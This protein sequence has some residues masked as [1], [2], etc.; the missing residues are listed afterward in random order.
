MTIAH[1][2]HRHIAK[3]ADDHVNLK[4]DD[5]KKYREQVNRLR[6]RLKEK[7]D[8]DS[9]IE[10]RRMLLS[11]SLAKGTALKNLNDIDVAVY[12]AQSARPRPA[13][14][15]E[16]QM[17]EFLDWLVNTLQRLFPNMTPKQVKQQSFSVCVSFRGT[18]LDV[19]VVPIS[20]NGDPAWNGHLYSPMTRTWL[21][22]NIDKH[23]AFI[24][25][26][27]QANDTHYVQVIRLLKY[28]V[29][30]IK[31]RNDDFKFKSFLVELLVAHLADCGRIRLDDYV[32]ALAGFFDFL[33]QGGL[34]DKIIFTDY[35]AARQFASTSDPVQVFDPVNP[36]N[37]VADGYTRNDKS[38]IVSA[39]ATAADAVDGAIYAP[40]KTDAVRY[41][42]KIFGS[43]FQG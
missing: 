38:A 28:W 1:I 39:A 20:Y 9:R 18:D 5:A 43:S 21:M 22:T 8:P 26:R 13:P 23:L 6:D 42:Q 30:E 34:N 15:S 12:V 17:S 24:K 7:A 14:V 40:T 25:K 16:R 4:R 27:K 31:K 41:W 2:A 3:F 10:L 19:D 11:G 37:N 33:V 32:E 35:H 36:E 29:K